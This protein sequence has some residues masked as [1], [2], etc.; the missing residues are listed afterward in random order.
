M[1]AEDNYVG[2][3]V[4]RAARIAAAGRG[5][6]VLVSAATAA[7]RSFRVART[8]ANRSGCGK[9]KT[10]LCDVKHRR[11]RRPG[12]G[13]SAGSSPVAPA[14]CLQIGMFLPE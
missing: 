9:T 1:I 5:R 12:N 3:D 6:Q 10:S 2:I 4:H 14:K 8:G 13:H 11:L 7:L